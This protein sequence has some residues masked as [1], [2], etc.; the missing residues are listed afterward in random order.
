M[1]GPPHWLACAWVVSL[2]VV[3]A[4]CAGMAGVAAVSDWLERRTA[5]GSPENLPFPA[6]I[7]SRRRPN[8]L[9]ALPPD[10][11]PQERQP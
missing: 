1:S 10:P 9:P 3:A 5:R 2:W 4:G 7:A 8:P 11:E 6:L